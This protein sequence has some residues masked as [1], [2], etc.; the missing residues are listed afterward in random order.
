MS[1]ETAHAALMDQVYRYQRYIYDLT[2]KYFLFGR[3]RLIR[4]LDLRP[5]ET[6]VEIGCGT[7]RN[8]IRMA[9]RYPEASFY[10]LDASQEMLKTAARKIARAGLAGRIQLVHGYAEALTPALFAREAPFDR[11]VFSYSLSMI[12]D[13]HQAVKSALA[14]L[15]PNGRLHA[16]DFGDLAGL[17]WPFADLLRGWLNLFHVEPRTEILNT[18]EHNFAAN[19]RASN[20]LSILPARYAFVLNCR[21]CD[22]PSLSK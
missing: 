10:G 9:R 12:P 3:D 7:A 8:L 17:R 19:A 20:D 16:V 6:V 14:S 18:V 4:E 5:G 22:V 15:S 1:E 21:A 11:V 2:R 13:W